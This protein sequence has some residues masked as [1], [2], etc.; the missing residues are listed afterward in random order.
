MPRGRRERRKATSFALGLEN[1][2]LIAYHAAVFATDSH[3]AFMDPI[4]QLQ[5]ARGV[6]LHHGFLLWNRA[7]GGTWILGG[8]RPGLIFGA[9]SFG[10]VSLVF[11]EHWAGVTSALAA[12]V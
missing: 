7:S 2:R 8:C 1:G 6:A 4:L 11:L 10:L 5:V 12:E 9:P 3:L